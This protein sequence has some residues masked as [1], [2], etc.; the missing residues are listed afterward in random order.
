MQARIIKETKNLK[1]EAS[2]RVSERWKRDTG[3]G[4]NAARRRA[5]GVNEER[6]Q[7]RL[8]EHKKG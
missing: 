1:G 6:S 4:S 3:P 7:G 8:A 5:R 2:T